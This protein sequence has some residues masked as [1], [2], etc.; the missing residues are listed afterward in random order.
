MFFGR[1]DVTVDNLK[2]LCTR[3]GW[4]T[5]RNGCFPKGSIPANKGKKMPFNAASARTRFKKGNRPHTYKGPGHEYIDKDGYVILIVSDDV[6]YPSCPNRETRTVLK[7]RWE[8]ERKHGPIPEGQ[9]LKCL[10][11]DKTNCDPSNW[12]L[13]PRGVMP[14]LAGRWGLGYDE[15]PD[16]LKP[17]LLQTALLDHASREAKRKIGMETPQQRWQRL[18]RGSADGAP[19]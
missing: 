4:K 8:W 9:V 19:A 1:D 15:A 3:R 13:V 10:T 5:G 11:N 7:H 12:V 14:R 16:E 18:R 6:R 2:A 17:V